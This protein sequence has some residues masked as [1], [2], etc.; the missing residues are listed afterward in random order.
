MWTLAEGR[1]YRGITVE[2]LERNIAWA[3]SWQPLTGEEQER[4][5]EEGRTIATE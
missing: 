2:E 1:L 4:L 3:Q 5:A